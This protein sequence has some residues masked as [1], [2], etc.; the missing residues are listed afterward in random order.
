MANGFFFNQLDNRLNQIAPWARRPRLPGIELP[1]DDMIHQEDMMKLFNRSPQP[2]VPLAPGSS[3]SY[4][5]T[6]MGMPAM[7]ETYQPQNTGFNYG[8]PQWGGGFGF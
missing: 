7:Q 5:Q 8:I 1:M 3:T 6:S 4:Q 2:Y